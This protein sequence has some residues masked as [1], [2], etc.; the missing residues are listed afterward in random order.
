M[1]GSYDNKQ[2]RKTTLCPLPQNK[3]VLFSQRKK[4]IEEVQ[5]KITLWVFVVAN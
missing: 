2:T 4:K 1:F 3:I 5:K